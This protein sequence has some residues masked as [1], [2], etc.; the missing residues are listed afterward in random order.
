MILKKLSIESLYLGLESNSP[1][2]PGENLYNAINLT[3]TFLGA[4]IFYD[5]LFQGGE[6]TLAE[7][8]YMTFNNHLNQFRSSEISYI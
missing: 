8:F 1:P 7:L 5:F 2:Q 6:H 4:F 3:F